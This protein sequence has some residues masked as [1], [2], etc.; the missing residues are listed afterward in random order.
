M[1][2][3]GCRQRGFT[4]LEIVVVLVL[5]GIITSFALLSVS[6]DHTRDLVESEGQRLAALLRYNRDL[7]SLSLRDRGLLIS[8]AGYT[9]LERRGQQWVPADDG[10]RGRAT[11]PAGLRLQLNVEDL[12]KVLQQADEDD[13]KREREAKPQVW[14]F[15]SGEFLP[16]ELELADAAEEHRFILEGTAAGKLETRFESR[17]Q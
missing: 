13:D 4:L 8:D 6:A 15:S 5:V 2:S 14:I 9:L 12:P 7:A 17:V 1:W 3:R 10:P 11:L 16:F